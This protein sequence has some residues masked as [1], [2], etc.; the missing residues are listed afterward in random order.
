MVGNKK[1]RD[2]EFRLFGVT[3]KVCEEGLTRRIA[4]FILGR[5][6]I[7]VVAAAAAAAAA[8]VL[9]LPVL[10]ALLSLLWSS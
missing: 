2:G 10:L 3:L 6:E 4:R 8:A 9:L 7:R 1:Y 5:E